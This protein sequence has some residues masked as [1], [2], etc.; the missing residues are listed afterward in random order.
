YNSSM[1]VEA[2]VQA[3]R[4][5]MTP[6][7][8]KFSWLMGGIVTGMIFMYQIGQEPGT[9][10]AALQKTVGD[11]T[12]NL[13]DLKTQVSDLKGRLS[14]LERQYMATLA[15]ADS[16]AVLTLS[17]RYY[18]RIDTVI[19]KMLVRIVSAEPYLDGIKIR[20]AIGNPH[21]VAMSGFTMSLQW[22]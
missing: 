17:E 18:G 2:P 3:N 21:S 4:N 14:T 12:T 6:G 7:L 13:I 10:A 9:Q 20:F 1:E 15:A 5:K 16:V 8:G 11:L 19:G 22:E